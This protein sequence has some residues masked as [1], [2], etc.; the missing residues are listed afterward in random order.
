MNEVQP[1]P[2][3]TRR[4]LFIVCG[5]A[6]VGKTTFGQR[7]AAQEQACLLDID[8]V[9]ER[10]VQAGL[11]AAGMDIN[12]R[13]SPT[14]KQLYRAAIHDTLFDVA[15]QNLEHCACVIVAPFTQERRQPTFLEQCVA[16]VT[17]SVHVYYLVCSEELRKQRIENR[18]NPRD[19]NKLRDWDQYS[20]VGYDAE[21]PPFTHQL[22]CTD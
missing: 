7:L 12:D 9:S 20:R 6:G 5:N 19:R 11:K 8:T 4:P 10:L 1:P 2:P 22:I 3:P 18:N 21:P 13:D 16:R 14:Y 15:D 17:T